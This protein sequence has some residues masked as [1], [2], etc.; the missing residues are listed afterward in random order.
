MLR[1]DITATDLKTIAESALAMVLFTDAAHASER[2][3]L[4]HLVIDAVRIEM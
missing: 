1:I 3:I 2:G 4:L